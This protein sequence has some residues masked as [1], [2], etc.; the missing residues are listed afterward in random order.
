MEIGAVAEVL[1]D[2]LAAREA[3][4]AA[5]STPSPPIWIRPVVERS[6]HEAMKWQPMP[7]WAIEPSGHLWLRCCGAA[8]AEVGQPAHRVAGIRRTSG[9]V[10]SRTCSRRSRAGLWRASQSAKTGMIREGRSSPSADRSGAPSASACRMTRGRLPTR[11]KSSSLSWRF[12]HGAFF[13][14]HQD[15]VE[16]PSTKGR[17]ARRLERKDQPDLVARMPAASRSKP[18]LESAQHLEKVI[19]GLAAGDNAQIR[20]GSRRDPAV[21]AVLPRKARAASSLRARRCSSARLGRSG[22]R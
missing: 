19:V 2:M 18:Q 10:K 3:P 9:A 8:R 11:L 7:A 20:R 5:Q 14:H 12:D 16:E 1:E 17:D 4:V 22:Q 13:L 21:D 6:I 15:L